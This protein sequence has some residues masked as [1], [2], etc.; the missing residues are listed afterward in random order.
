MRKHAQTGLWMNGHWAVNLRLIELKSIH[1]FTHLLRWICSPSQ[2][3]HAP[4]TH[5]YEQF[6]ISY[7]P[8]HGWFWSVGGNQGSW[9][10]TYTDRGRTC[11]CMCRP[12]MEHPD[13]CNLWGIAWTTKSQEFFH[14]RSVWA[15]REAR[16]CLLYKDEWGLGW[17]TDVKV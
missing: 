3:T 7:Q 14:I 9:K 13:V 10:K 15:H 2:D 8:K 4:F 6:S 17:S 11:K 1:P 12:C 5:T 16:C